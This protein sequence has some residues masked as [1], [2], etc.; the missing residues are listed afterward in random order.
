M[1]ESGA[2][3]RSGRMPFSGLKDGQR[4]REGALGAIKSYE[5]DRHK[6]V[7][8]P[9]M[10][11]RQPFDEEIN[12]ARIPPHFRELL[13]YISE[14]D[15]AIRYK[16]F[17]GT[18]T[19][20][21]LQWFFAYLPKPST[22]TMTWPHFVANKTKKLGVTDLFNIKQIKGETLKKCLACFN[23]AT[24]QELH[25]GHFSDSLA[26]RRSIS[27][28]EIRA[29]AEKH[30]EAEEDLADRVVV[31]REIPSGSTKGDQGGHT[32]KGCRTLKGQIEKLICEG[33]LGRFVQT[34]RDVMARECNP[35]RPNHSEMPNEERP[36]KRS[37]LKSWTGSLY[38]G[39]IATIS[40]EET[41]VMMTIV[42]RK[43]YARSVMMIKA[44]LTRTISRDPIIS[45]SDKDYKDMMPHQY[46]PMVISIVAMEYK[47]ERVLVDQGSSANILSWK[48]RTHPGGGS[49]YAEPEPTRPIQKDDQ[50]RFGFDRSR[51][52]HFNENNS[53]SLPKDVCPKARKSNS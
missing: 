8:K 35:L 13:V 44:Y 3:R 27:M 17:L 51:H 45:F 53:K 19:G 18:L 43:R 47:I 11:W 23:S 34:Q 26:L 32:T 31:E 15:D 48:I 41:N 25:A 24:V 37:R 39:T 29:K 36:R 30:I 4:M 9:P 22:L 52:Q 12:Q 46:D 6:G 28:E 38:H 1:S 5:D 10:F 42:E 16:L 21:D 14:G 20:V 7:A 49:G 40:S 50:D 33:Y 2:C